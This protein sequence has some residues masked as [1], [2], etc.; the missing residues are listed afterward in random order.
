MRNVEG[1]RLILCFLLFPGYGFAQEVESNKFSRNT[2]FAEFNYNSNIDLYSILFDRILNPAKRV[3]IGFQTGVSISL[4]A[5]TGDKGYSAFFPIK[6][7]FLIGRTRHFFETGLGF[8]IAG[9]PF[10]D[11]NVGYRFKS[12]SNGLSLRVGYD[13]LIYFAG[14]GNMISISTGYT[15]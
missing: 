8:R 4:E 3:K 5:E 9:V 6:S 15:F 1:I 10:P 7:Y 2:F 13:G 12:I 14:L 11:F